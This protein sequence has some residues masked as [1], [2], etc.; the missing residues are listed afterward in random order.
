[1]KRLPKIFLITF[2][3]IFIL[4]MAC[5]IVLLTIPKESRAAE[6]NF[7]PQISIPGSSFGAGEKT[8]PSIAKYIQAIYNYAI[9]IVGI[10]AAVVLMVGGVIWLTAGGS[11]EKV[12]EAKAWIGAALS[13]LVLALTSYMILNTINPDLVSFKDIAPENIKKPL[14]NYAA[15]VDNGICCEYEKDGKINSTS[16]TPEICKNDYNGTSYPDKVEEPGSGCI[17]FT[18]KDLKIEERRRALEGADCANY[19]FR[20][21]CGSRGAGRCRWESTGYYDNQEHGN[22]LTI[23][24]WEQTNDCSTLQKTNYGDSFCVIAKPGEGYRCCGKYDN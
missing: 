10:L 20:N 15:V 17:T 1:M 23:Y 12:N 22:C 9:G 24:K 3:S 19:K 18:E 8:T 11:P 2:L 6:D 16:V 5:L 7:T 4:Q 13:G 14:D 21:L